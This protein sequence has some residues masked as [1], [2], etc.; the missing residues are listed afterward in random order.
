[1]KLIRKLYDWV[2]HWAHTP[3]GAIA[4]FII[5]FA[6]SSFFPIPPDVLL[7]A[8]NLSKPKKS[9]FYAAVCTVAAVLGGM[10]GYY[11]GL[12]FWDIGSKIILYYVGMDT[13]NYVKHQ[14]ELHAGLAIFIAGFGP[15]PYKV[16][17]ISAGFFH[18]N[19]TTFVIASTLSR[20]GRFFIV[21]TLIYIFGAPIKVFIDKYFNLL[22]I[23]FLLLVICGF[24]LL[25]YVI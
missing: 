5:S 25:K 7:I 20:G 8:L 9:F 22:C 4:L 16:F 3:Y 21:S 14:F 13:F 2:L 19:F 1:M 18:I 15:I 24:I 11:I 23:I 10:F 6:E 12:K 17:T